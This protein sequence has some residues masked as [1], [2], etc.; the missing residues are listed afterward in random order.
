MA[1]KT[2]GRTAVVALWSKYTRFLALAV[3]AVQGDE[4]G[5]VNKFA[6]AREF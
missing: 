3:I 1:S 6:V 4:C 2:S 5:P